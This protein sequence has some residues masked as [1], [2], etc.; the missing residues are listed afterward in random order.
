[1]DLV[2]VALLLF[3]GVGGGV[4]SAIAGGA[5]IVTFPILLA[6]G[7]TPVTAAVTNSV[8][9]TA[10]NVIAAATERSQLPPLGRSFWWLVVT[11]SVATLAGGALLM[12]TSERLFAILIPLLLGFATLLFAYTERI[13][14]WISARATARGDD[15]SHNW[16]SS[17]IWMM[18]VSVYGGYFGAGIGIM[19]LA[20]LTIGTG[21]DYRSANAIKNLL[22]GINTGAV[23]LYFLLYGPVAFPHVLLMTAGAL[24]GGFLGAR[25]ARWISNEAARWM[26]VVIGAILTI[27]FAWRYWF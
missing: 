27:A 16:N 14:A 25:V 11:S 7:I 22:V 19:A 24:A 3:A 21:G 10:S 26:V 13:T 23:A 18:P 9:L 15:G 20:V 4:I 8:A 17:I 12:L 6:T 1:M 5:S 2:S